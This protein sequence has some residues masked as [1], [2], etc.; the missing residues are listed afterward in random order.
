MNNFFSILV[1]AAL[2]S[3]CAPKRNDSP[4]NYSDKI[5]LSAFNDMTS[6]SSLDESQLQGLP[7]IIDLKDIQSSVK[8]QNDRGTCTF[9]ATA[10]LIESAVKKDL[11]KDINIS[12]EFLNYS[13]KTIPGHFADDEGS[14][15]RYNAIAF[16]SQGFMLERDWSYQTSWF[17]KGLP[18]ESY[19][20]G[21]DDTP[22]ICYSHNGPKNESATKILSSRGV[23]IAS[24]PKNTSKMIRFLAIQKRPFSMSI[25]VNFS[26]WPNTGDVVYNEELRNQCLQDNANCGGHVIVITGY[27]LDRKVF[28]FKNSWGKSWGKEGFGTVTFE[29]VDRYV[30]GDLYYAR[31]TASL[32]LPEDYDKDYLTLDKFNPTAAFTENG[33]LNVNVDMQASYANGRVIYL[34]TYLAQKDK[35]LIEAPTTANTSS[36]QIFENESAVAGGE[37]NIKSVAYYFTDTG[38]IIAPPSGQNFVMAIPKNIIELATV[39]TLLSSTTQDAFMRTTI[40]THTD[41]ESFKLLKRVWIPIKR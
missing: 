21:K 17:G 27:D 41:D 4:S 36:V 13:A 33:D 12:E 5:V 3:S 29:N 37:K 11:K 22:A 8:N 1:L 24:F 9:F 14:S 20:S 30:T 7:K 39:N 40:Y 35:N 2:L 34:S 38:G 23:D 10:A 19:T 25:N 6:A 28:F 18:C 15:V 26:G 31:A 16:K 32:V